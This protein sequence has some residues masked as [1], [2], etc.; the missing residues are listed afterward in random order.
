MLS[1]S[2]DAMQQCRAITKKAAKDANF[3]VCATMSNLNCA[4]GMPRQM[5]PYP[6]ALDFNT[7]IKASCGI[8]TLP[9]DFI[10]FLPSF[11]FSKSL[12]LRVMSPP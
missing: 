9:M 10:R 7:A 5:A 8:F 2:S 6:P 12:R 4:F 3:I 1:C 11:C